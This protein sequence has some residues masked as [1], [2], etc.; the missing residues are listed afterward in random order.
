MR[1]VEAVLPGRAVATA[2]WPGGGLAVL[3][4]AEDPH[5]STGATDGEETYEDDERPRALYRLRVDPDGGIEATDLEPVAVDLPADLDALARVGDALFAGAR[6]E[7][8]EESSGRLL[9]WRDD[10]K[11]FELVFEHPSLDLDRLARAGLIH[12][13]SIAVPEVGR[14]VHYRFE[15]DRFEGDEPT[16][17]GETPL[18]AFTRRCPT[19]F[20]MTSP[21]VERLPPS[22]PDAGPRYVAGPVASGATRLRSILIDPSAE[23]PVANAW[24]RLPSPEDVDAH[25]WVTID[26]RPYLVAITTDAERLGVFEKSKLRVLPLVTDRTRAGRG[27]TFELETETRNWYAVGVE[28]FDEDGDGRDDL[29]VLQPQGLSGGDLVVEVFRGIGDGRFDRRSRKEEID[30]AEGAD[31]SFDRDWT[32]DG[33]R[34]L[35]VVAEGDLR[36]YPGSDHRRRPVESDPAWSLTA[37]AT[38]AARTIVERPGHADAPT[39]FAYRGRLVVENLDAGPESDDRPEIVLVRTVRDRAL[40][41]IVSP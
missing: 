23:E 41:R 28:I 35:L 2:P 5:R 8:D 7:D 31:W 25:H 40:V 26:G 21:P 14:L 9:R 4:A 39:R 36:L 27:A 17:V 18:P 15:G 34:D 6:G 1:V 13:A 37:E 29:V 38:A 19:G 22:S 30:D 16:I 10:E 24:S 3:V 11:H 20:E 32:G 33:R 12:D